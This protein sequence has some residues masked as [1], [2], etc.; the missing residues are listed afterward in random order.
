[1]TNKKKIAYL[2]HGLY[3]GGA[4]T[5]L[6]LLIK[7]VDTSEYDKLLY[8]ISCR[9]AEMKNDFLKHCEKVELVGLGPIYND[10]AGGKTSVWDLV[11]K[12]IFPPKQ[13]L[14]TLRENHV[15]IL[16]INSSVFPH[17]HK[18]VKENSNIKIVTHVRE[19]IPKHGLGL[20]QRYM[21]GQIYKYSDAIIAISDNEAK[22]FQGHPHLHVFP[23]PFDFFQID[24]VQSDYR[25]N[26]RISPEVVLVGMMGQFHRSKGHLDMLKALKIILDKKAAKYPFLFVLIG[27]SPELPRWKLLIK[28]LLFKENYRQEVLNYIRDNGMENHVKMVPYSYR[29]FDR[30][31]AMDI[32]VRP[33][34]AG[35]P[36]GRDIIESMAFGKP[37]VVTGSSEYFVRDGVN[38]YLVPPRDPKK[39]AGKIVE[40][41]NDP[42]KRRAFG[43]SGRLKALEMCDLFEYGAKIMGVYQEILS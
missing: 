28:K 5:S 4:T 8:V 37:L 2:G 24:Q 17:I 3:F 40:L 36:W 25:H 9:S 38:G 14:R 31:K 22:Y 6:Y 7:S 20:V 35:D 29:V 10:Q 23:N 11:R 27:I 39:L 13:L 18:M 21:I 12:I 41:I 1:M 42:E 43:E 15:D 34:R 16:H 33:S 30:L 32:M 19:M 26:D